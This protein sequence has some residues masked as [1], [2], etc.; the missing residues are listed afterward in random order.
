MESGPVLLNSYSFANSQEQTF[1]CFL[2]L[3]GGFYTF[4]IVNVPL[5]KLKT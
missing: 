2:D 1:F 4:Y 5:C 3:L